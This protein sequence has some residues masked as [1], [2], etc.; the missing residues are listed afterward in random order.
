[1][2]RTI[3]TGL[4]AGVL[5]FLGYVALQ[6][7]AYRV[8]RSATIAAP[9]EAVFAHVN[10]L[11]KWEAWSP[12]A[13]RDPNAKATFEGP[14]AGTGAVMGWSGNDEVGEGKMTIVDSKPSDA[15]KIKLDFVKPFAG[16]SDVAFDF[17]P[18]GGKTNVTWSIAG[19]QGFMERAICTLMGGMDKMIGADYEAGLASLKSVVEG[20]KSG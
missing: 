11:K 5:A 15:I 1:M 7:P 6:P 12:W 20:G 14:A 17:K 16:T 13:K 19:E 10:D 3:L 2:F 8:V 9:P 4:A 18:D